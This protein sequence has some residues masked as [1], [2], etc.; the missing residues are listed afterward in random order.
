[1]FRERKTRS[2]RSRRRTSSQEQLAAIRDAAEANAPEAL[3][4]AAQSL[5]SSSAHVGAHG[6]AN[7]C[8]E[9]AALCHNGSTESARQLVDR[10]TTELESV[11]EELAVES[12][13][14]RES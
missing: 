13:G 10:L 11:H 6:L 14:V 2:S 5:H 4:R 12:F 9:L 3:A 8:K 1:M 7:L